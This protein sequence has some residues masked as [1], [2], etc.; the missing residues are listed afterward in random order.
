MSRDEG[1]GLCPY[2]VL[3]EGRFQT[4][5]VL[6]ERE[7]NNP[8]RKL[9]KL[10]K[11]DLAVSEVLETIAGPK[12][13]HLSQISLAYVMSKTPYVFPIVGAR[14]VEHIQGSMGGLAVTLTEGEVD[15]IEGAYDFDPGFPHTFLSGTL[16]DGSKPRMADKPGDVWLTKHAGDID[17]V[18]G[19]K[20]IRLRET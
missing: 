11:N 9:G 8:G 1:M 5:A 19:Q 16:I 7:T 4:K 20:A 2:G 6:K 18:E 3:G 14:T 12:G 10:S 13:V 15:M 17:W